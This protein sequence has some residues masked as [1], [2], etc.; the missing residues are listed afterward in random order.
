MTSPL[1]TNE[2]VRLLHSIRSRTIE[3][4]SNFKSRYGND[5]LLCD[6]CEEQEE[7]DQKHIL[8]CKTLNSFFNSEE[9]TKYSVKY[10]DVFGDHHRQKV[11][12]T[13]FEKLL[14]IRKTLT[15]E[16]LG[17]KTNPSTPL[18]MLKNCYNVQ[19]SIVN[20]SFGT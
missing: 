17:N 15:E 1:F 12:V 5:D 9:V 11:V 13:I 20:F 3:C 19:P 14:N 6:L 7:D 2:E 8:Y 16:K 18:R 4:K 10:N